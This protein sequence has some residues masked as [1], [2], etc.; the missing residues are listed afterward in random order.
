MLVTKPQNKLQFQ[1]S[2]SHCGLLRVVLHRRA[3][4]QLLLFFFADVRS[5]A[6]QFWQSVSSISAFL[7]DELAATDDTEPCVYS[8]TQV[9][10]PCTWFGRDIQSISIDGWAPCTGHF[11]PLPGGGG[12]C[13]WA[14]NLLWE[15]W[16]ANLAAKFPAG[17]PTPK[18]VGSGGWWCKISTGR[19]G[20]CQADTGKATPS[21][22]PVLSTPSPNPC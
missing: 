9:H 15:I 1:H 2:H 21:P 8:T 12:G 17:K 3:R 10:A 4:K 16:Q 11:L 14:V 7:E 5:Q 6:T 22:L 18:P 19:G 13:W 20:P